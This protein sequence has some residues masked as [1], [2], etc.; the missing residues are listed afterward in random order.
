MSRT[1]ESSDAQGVLLTAHGSVEDLDD[2]AEFLKRIRHGRPAPP[3]LVTEVR[4]RYE[5]I[6]GSPLLRITEQQAEL[7]SK[8]LGLPVYIGMRLSKPELADALAQARRD[9]V[10][11]LCVLPL[12]PY[13]VHVYA[14]AAEKALAAHPH[15]GELS[16][17]PVAPFGTSSELVAA[18]AARIRESLRDVGDGAEVVLTAHSLPQGVIDGGDPY[19]HE[20]ELSA[21]AIGAA[22]GRHVELAYQSQGFGGGAW[23]G[24]DLKSVFA[25]Q[26]A[27]G[28]REVVVAPV[29]FLADHVETLYDLAIEAKA[30]ADEL[31]LGF[32][33]VPALNT[34][35]G[36]IDA[37]AAA[38]RRALFR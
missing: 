34:A 25:A 37:L 2:L 14:A 7:L 11:T 36:L 31:G 33:R 38:V 24:P 8:Q 23:L 17:V 6:G 4:R 9:G 26:K 27:R 15:Q 20:F 28:V 3:E 1:S 12:A 22:L 5:A 18:H 29:G 21:R 35:P 30:W 16:L 32:T 13:S 19:Q 10:R